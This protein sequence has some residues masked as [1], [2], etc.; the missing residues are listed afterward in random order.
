MSYPP[1]L[2]LGERGDRTATYRRH[3]HEAELRRQATGTNIHYL[4]TGASTGGQF[5]LYRWEM[6]AG[7]GGPDP[8]FH[9]TIS[10]SFYTLEGSIAIFDGDRWIDTEPGD[11]VHVPAGGLHGFKNTSGGPREDAPAFFPRCAARGLLR[12]GP[13][14]AR[15]VG[16]RAR[17]VLFEA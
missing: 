17:S 14:H 12:T 7:R 11:W 8:H 9:R 5:G 16:R 10:E 4:A 1:P 13:E 15:Q 6:G 2:Y 3:D